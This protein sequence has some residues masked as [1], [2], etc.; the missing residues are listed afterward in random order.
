M[1]LEFVRCIIGYSIVKP[2]FSYPNLH[3]WEQ[4]WLVTK[5]SKKS[6]FIQS[7]DMVAI[8]CEMVLCQDGTEALVRI[9]AVD[10]NLEVLLRFIPYDI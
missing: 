9:C 8:D 10:R 2:N 7:K 4:D 1:A 6:N 5:R 3:P